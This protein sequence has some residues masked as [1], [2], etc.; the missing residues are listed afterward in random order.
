MSQDAAGGNARP[1]DSAGERLLAAVETGVEI[2]AHPLANVSSSDVRPHHL[3]AVLAAARTTVDEGAD[4]VVLTH[5]TDTLE[6][7][8]FLLERYWDREA[9]L[10]VTGA[11]R[12]ASDLGADGPANLRDAV[13]AAPAAARSPQPRRAAR[14]PP[15]GAGAHRRARRAPRAPRPPAG[16]AAAGA[17]DR[18][19]G[20][21][22]RLPRRDAQA[23][24]PARRRHARRGRLTHR[25]GRHLHRSLRLSGLRGGS[26]GGGR[27]D[28]RSA[29]GAEGAPA[30]AGAA[31]G[32]RAHG[33][34]PRGDR[35]L[36]LLR[37]STAPPTAAATGHVP[38]P[39]PV[40]MSA[41][42]EAPGPP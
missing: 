20:D 2:Q 25:H 22:A 35:G 39:P 4:G 18:R 26:A 27:G 30:A 8:A 14:P 5:G 42:G 10:V 28:G 17:G 11:M 33:A 24:A 9:P 15:R 40:V 37:P 3:A 23:A 32:R 29:A 38:A 6:E 13:R 21:G 7:T 31:R 16:R 19:G 41:P 36:R 34:D 12:P 1:D